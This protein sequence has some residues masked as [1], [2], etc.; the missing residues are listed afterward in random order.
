MK[1]ELSASKVFSSMAVFDLLRGQ[2]WFAQYCVK[3]AIN[4][5]VS[6]GRLNDFLKHVSEI[7]PLKFMLSKLNISQTELLDSFISKKT[8]E[9]VLPDEPA[10]DNIGFRNA[11]FSWSNNDESGGTLTPS[12][13]RFLLKI[14]GEIY[15]KP[16]GI[17]LV[18]GPTGSVGLLPLPCPL[19]L[20][21][22]QGKTSLLMAL[23][24]GCSII[25][26]LICTHLQLTQAR[27]TS[28]PL[29]LRRG[30]TC[31]EVKASHTSH[32]KAG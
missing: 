3:M 29:L 22:S 18:I 2:L 10:S 11:I 16:G 19:L 23:L 24:G 32:R 12:G 14:E 21:T 30:S 17:N 15:F 25:Q 31:R 9:M 26:P 28:C 20:H 6:L 7:C 13:R 4:G 1:Q 8:S 5:R 27:C